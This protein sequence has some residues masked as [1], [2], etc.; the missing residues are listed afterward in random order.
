MERD[1]VQIPTFSPGP[2]GEVASPNTRHPLVRHSQRAPIGD[3]PVP[4]TIM[5][6]AAPHAIWTNADLPDDLPDGIFSVPPA[7]ETYER[8]VAAAL[9]GEDFSDTVVQ[10]HA[11]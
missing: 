10:I 4:N 3:Q 6:R 9:P 1:F 8:F 7:A 5:S 2:V 11:A